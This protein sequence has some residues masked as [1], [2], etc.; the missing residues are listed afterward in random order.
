MVL[1]QG[2]TYYI[3]PTFIIKV[4]SCTT[5]TLNELVPCPIGI[6]TYITFKGK[7]I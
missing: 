7:F 3:L 1:Y 5:C 2:A 4:K 6:E